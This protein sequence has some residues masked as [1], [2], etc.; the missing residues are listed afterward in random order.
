MQVKCRVIEGPLK[1]FITLRSQ[2]A[3]VRT[4]ERVSNL[5]LM[6]MHAFVITVFMHQ[7]ATPSIRT[8]FK[9]RQVIWQSSRLWINESPLNVFAVV[10]LMIPLP[11][12][13]AIPRPPQKFDRTQW[14]GKKEKPGISMMYHL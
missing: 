6:T 8:V 2:N 5:L 9:A 11:W 12:T 4:E 7:L 13:T 10:I 14:S 1:P 3:D